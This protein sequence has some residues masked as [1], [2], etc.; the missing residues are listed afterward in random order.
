M[1]Y[2]CVLKLK[3]M[4]AVGVIKILGVIVILLDSACGKK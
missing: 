3:I 1:Q 2:T 4:R